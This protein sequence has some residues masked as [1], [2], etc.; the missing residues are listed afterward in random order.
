MSKIGEMALRFVLFSPIV[1]KL[2]ILFKLHGVYNQVMFQRN[3][4]GIFNRSGL[5]NVSSVVFLVRGS[6]KSCSVNSQ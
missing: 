6:E 5:R 4:L 2:L 1:I 3:R